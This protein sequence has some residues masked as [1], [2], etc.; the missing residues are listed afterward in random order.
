MSQSPDK[1]FVVG[2]PISHSRSPDIHTLFAQQTQ[3]QLEYTAQEIPIDDFSN[4]IAQ[5]KQLGAKGF[6]VTV[7]FKAEAFELC[8]SLSERAAQTGSVNTISISDDGYIGDT[9]DGR[10]LINDLQINHQINLKDKEILI[11]GAGGAVAG[12]VPD[13]FAQN[14][15]TIHIANRTLSK[16]EALCQ[17]FVELG[18]VLFSSMDTIPSKPFDVIINATSAS[19]SNTALTLPKT[20]IKASTIA[21][22]MVYAAKPTPFLEWS[23]A[24]G[25]ALAIDGL[26]MLVEQAAESFEIWRGVKPKTQTVIQVLRDKLLAS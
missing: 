18:D 20:C 5:L 4:G 3:Q 19:L 14:I 9:T 1:Y 13:F 16:A 11:L 22:D 8:T 26:G 15:A 6:N 17:R 23:K 7:P 2:N 25:A 24:Q 21:Y 10:G 12:V